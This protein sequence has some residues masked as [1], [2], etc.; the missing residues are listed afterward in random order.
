MKL[1][2]TVNARNEL[3]EIVTYIWHDNPAAAKRLRHRIETTASHLTSRPLMGRPG[4]ISGTREAI[5]HP[6]YRLVYEVA[7]DTVY[8]LRIVHTARLWP[9]GTDEGDR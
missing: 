1:V 9:P 3:A 4:A 8:I 7:E 6:S 5:S 2:W